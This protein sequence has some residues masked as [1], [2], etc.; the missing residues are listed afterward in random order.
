MTGFLSTRDLATALGVS[1]SSVRRWVDEQVIRGSKT[2]GGHRRIPVAEAFRFIRQR[3]MSLADPSL[4]GLPDLAE[5]P[6]LDGDDRMP[7]IERALMAG[8][9][10]KVVGSILWLHLNGKPAHWIFDHPLRSA[11]TFIGELWLNSEQGIMLEHRATDICVRAVTRLRDMLPPPDRDAPAAVGGAPA[12]DPYFLPTA[13]AATSLAE[14]GYA[15]INLGGETPSNVL[16]SAVDQHQAKLAWMSFTSPIDQPRFLDELARLA[17]ELNERG[18]RFVVGGRQVHNGLPHP[19]A[20]VTA[21][22]SMTALAKFAAQLSDPPIH[23]TA[24]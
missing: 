9:H 23:S 13:M 19:V 2:A 12:G 11:M 8:D 22:A 3:K 10:E 6:D 18:C 21:L 15:S 7:E 1:E 5:M 4:L 14:I 16:L 20:N 17:A 24:S